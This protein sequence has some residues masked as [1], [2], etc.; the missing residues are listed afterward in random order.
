VTDFCVVDVTTFGAGG[1]V[2]FSALDTPRTINIDDSLQFA[3]TS[4]TVTAD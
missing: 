4:I 2:V 3:D 1:I